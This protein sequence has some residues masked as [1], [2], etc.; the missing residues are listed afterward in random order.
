MN[1]S[2]DLTV[3]VN[4]TLLLPHD[5]PEQL[6]SGKRGV[7]TPETFNMSHRT[8]PSHTLVIICLGVFT[9]VFVVGLLIAIFLVRRNR[10]LCDIGSGVDVR[11]QPVPQGEKNSPHV[12][13]IDHDSMAVLNTDGYD[14]NNEYDPATLQRGASTDTFRLS[15]ASRKRT[16]SSIIFCLN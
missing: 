10:A 8:I 16:V 6:S 4:A 15:T 1:T 13:A 5:Y 3:L 12:L 2:S 14:P 11:S 7:T 9:F